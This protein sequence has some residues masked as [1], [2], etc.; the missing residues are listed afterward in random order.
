[1][2]WLTFWGEPS[3]LEAN[4][5]HLVWQSDGEICPGLSRVII[6]ESTDWKPRL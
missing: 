2:N 6:N 4:T 5:D 3:V 1:M